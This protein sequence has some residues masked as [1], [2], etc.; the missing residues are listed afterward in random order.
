[1]Y[2]IKN[3]TDNDDVKV[4][5]ELGPFKV[6]EYQRDLSVTPNSAI[7]AYYSSEMNVRK[8]QLICDLSKA[9]ITIQAGAMQWM[10]GNVNATTGVKGVGDFLGKAMRG[11]VT[12][13]SA[14]KPEYTGDGLLVLEP[15]YK[16]L[17]LMDTASWGGSVVLDDGLF[18]ACDSS[19]KHKAVMR[20]NL[21]SAVA[22]SEGLFNLSLNG[23]GVFCI[24][25]E[26]PKEELI[27]ITLQNDVLKIDGNYAIAWST[28]LGFTV[29]RSGKSLIGS[30]ASGEG[31]VNVYRGSGKVLMVPTAKMPNF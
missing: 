7:T 13:E 24:E 17:I 19:L 25:S 8:R 12:G 20:S 15:T 23:N 5:S 14:I 27:E 2:Q 26:C 30:A 28:S 1:M 18:L 9:N 6:A 10:L 11:K 21:S 16:H 3:F 4:I 31:L 22:G 29:E